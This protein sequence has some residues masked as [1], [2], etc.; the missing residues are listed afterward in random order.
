ML[1]E[2]QNNLAT[3]GIHIDISSS[4][5]MN[6]SMKK[7]IADDYPGQCRA[8]VLNHITAKAMT[9]ARYFCAAI[10]ES[11]LDYKHYALSIPIYTHFTSPIRRYADI[12]VHRLLAASLNYR[13]K[14][15]W[16]ADYVQAIAAN[17]N[18]QKYNAKRAG[19]ASC[20]LY[21]AHYV[22]THQPFEQ[23]CVVVDVKDRSF[24]VIVLKTGS[25]IRIYQNSCEEG[26]TWQT[27]VISNITSEIN[28]TEGGK[29]KGESEKKL[30]RLKITFPKT[31]HFP[32]S[33]LIVELFTSVKVNLTRHNSYKLE[34]TLLRPIVSQSFTRQ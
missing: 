14:P 11:E 19:E 8:A 32:E 22:E 16:D 21:L 31:K 34:G 33:V 7:Y 30:Y 26:T 3:C 27:E 10:M 23:D 2:L 9:R 1:V 12:M 6:A 25:I 5:G 29:A 20:D 18:A 24:D 13:E 28:R 15:E 17:C 4:G